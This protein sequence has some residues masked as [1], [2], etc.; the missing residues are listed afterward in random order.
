SHRR[1]AAAR[2]ITVMAIVALV[3]SVL[4]M[5]SS[6]RSAR[7]ATAAPTVTPVGSQYENASRSVSRDGGLTVALP[8][9]KQLWIF[10]DTGIFNRNGSGQMVMNSFIGGTT[11]AEGTYAAGQVPTSL[12]EVP[13]PGKPLSLSASNAPT[14]YVP[15]PNDVYLPDGSGGKCTAP[16]A[17]YSA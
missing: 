12:Q 8:N 15:T 2:T 1:V 4:W 7:A 9:G 13:S 11:A 5:T 3:A 17:G 16:A 14:L 10:G 6:P